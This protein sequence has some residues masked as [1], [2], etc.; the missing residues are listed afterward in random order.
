MAEVAR[1]RAVALRKSLNEF[2]YLRTRKPSLDDAEAFVLEALLLDEPKQPQQQQFRDH[3]TVIDDSTKTQENDEE[4]R[5]LSTEVL[6]SLPP[7]E[8]LTG[9]R[10]ELPAH[11]KPAKRFSVKALWHAHEQGYHASALVSRARKLSNA[12]SSEDAP[13]LGRNVS[14]EK[15]NATDDDDDDDDDVASDVEVRPDLKSDA[16]AASSWDENDHRDNYDTW[17]VLKDEYAQDFG[18]DYSYSPSG[19]LEDILNDDESAGNTFSILGTSANDPS[20]QPHVLS[21]PLMDAISNFLPDE[22]QGQNFWLRYSLVRDGASLDTMRN[23]VR[24][25]QYTIIAIETPK[26]EV[27]G[28]F[29]SSPWRTAMGYFGGQPCFVWKM[30]HNRRTKCASL[31]EQAQLESEIDVFMSTHKKEHVQVCRHDQLAVGGDDDGDHQATVPE[32][33]QQQQQ[34]EVNLDESG[35]AFSLED[36]LLLGTTSACK[37]FRSPPLVGTNKQSK[38]FDVAGLE[39]WSFTPCFDVPAAQKLEMT[40]YFLEESIRGSTGSNSS[41]SLGSNRSPQFTRNDLMSDRFYQRVGQ[42]FESQER[43]D[44][45]EYTNMMHGVGNTRGTGGMQSPRFA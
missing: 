1:E 12:E 24:G 13:L 34:G 31:F 39:V 6:F 3:R 36:D 32:E 5:R 30:R 38:V 19:S 11:H 18:F 9:Q 22:L 2:K 10:A 26:G 23:Y 25:A 44:R 8:S 14:T 33:Q 35:F 20:V 42:D 4:K 45:W 21:P 37:S 41:Q 43:R 7:A 16:S 28:S 27:F 29:T 40:K 17:E 15:F